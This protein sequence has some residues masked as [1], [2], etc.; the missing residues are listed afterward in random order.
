MTCYERNH[1][2]DCSDSDNEPEDNCIDTLTTIYTVI[3]TAKNTKN[4]LCVSLGDN[5]DYLICNDISFMQNSNCMCDIEVRYYAKNNNRFTFF[6][7]D[8]KTDDETLLF[9]VNRKKKTMKIKEL[10]FSLSECSYREPTL[11]LSFNYM[12]YSV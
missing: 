3:D 5:E 11:F 12:N 6:T 10:E 2:L 8:K 9:T 1:T 7:L 4:D